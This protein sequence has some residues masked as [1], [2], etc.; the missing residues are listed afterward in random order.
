MQAAAAQWDAIHSG[1]QAET[2]RVSRVQ[3]ST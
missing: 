2:L 3:H 1:T